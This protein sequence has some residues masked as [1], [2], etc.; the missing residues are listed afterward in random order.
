MKKLI[1]FIFLFLLIIFSTQIAFSQGFEES[2]PEI[3]TSIVLLTLFDT[4]K[5]E[6]Y[7]KNDFFELFYFSEE[8]YVLIP[9]NLI[10][11]YLGVEL[12]FN[13]EL[14]L[15]TLTKDE[16]EIK[17]DLKER[18]YIDHNEWNDEKAIVYGG[19]FYL[20]KKVFSYLTDYQFTWN[21]SFQ[22]LLVEGEFIEKF[23]QEDIEDITDEEEKKDIYKVENKEI[24]GEELK[25]FQLSS[26]H[27]KVEV[28]LEDMRYSDLSKNIVSDLNF[29]GR[30][31]NWAYFLNNDLKYNIDNSEV[32]YDLDRIKFKYQEN[33]ILIIA[34]DHEINMKNTMGKN[35]IQGLYFSLPDKLSFKLIPYTTLKIDLKKGDDLNLLVN[36]KIAKRE[37]TKE[38]KELIIENIELKAGYLNKI[39]III[40]DKDGNKTK[41]TKYLAGAIEILQPKV[42][43]LELM[44]GRFKDFNFPDDEW[45][46]YFGAIR[47]YYALNENMSLYLESAIYNESENPNSTLENEILS[48]ITGFSMRLRDNT[49]INL[50]WLIAGEF[51]NLESGA[52]AEILYSILKG[53]IKAIY[54]YIPPETAEYMQKD[55]GENK[56]ISL[57]FDLNNN[58]TINPVIGQK[59]TLEDN[60]D[61]SDYY[62]FR[63]IY[64]PSWRNYN[65]LSLYY[66]DNTSEYIFTDQDNQSYIFLGDKIRKGI[67]VENNIYGRTFRVSSNLGYYD[68]EIT[69]N[70][71]YKENYQDYEAQLGLYKRFGNYLLFTGNYDGEQQRD[72][73][74][75]RYYDREYNAEL[76]LSLGERISLSLKTKRNEEE[77]ENRIDEESNFIL[78]YYFNRDFS[79]R[80]GFKDY[81]SEFLNDYQSIGLSGSYYYPNNPG[82]ITLS[83]EYIIPD[84]GD[85]GTSFSAAYD[86]IRNDESEIKIE[87]GREY[88]DFANNGYE[89]YATISYS[90]A[91]SF[92][93][94]ETRKTRF[95][96]FEPR[97]IV[98][99]YAYLDE[100]YNGVMDEGERKL[101]DIP[102]R[103]GNM[104]SVSDEEGFYI[105][106]PYFNDTYFLNFDYRNLIADYTPVT[107]EIMVRVKDN[108]NIMQNFGVTINGTISGNVFIDKNANGVKDENDEYLMWA[109]M[110]IVDL[111]K[112]D[113]TDQT[114]EFYFQNV[115]LGF[116]ELILL[117][118]S[119]PKGTK[120]LNGYKQEIFITED[121]LDYQD[122]NIPIVYGD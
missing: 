114:G 86:I 42:K 69:V 33:N 36:N 101:E 22:E 106:K 117:E 63:V 45:E 58:W 116:H 25:G 37:Y 81:H 46:G 19:E 84:E 13:R 6:V 110:E 102:M 95:T 115:P 119:L 35:D 23:S 107:E 98:A 44:G 89:N 39:E 47:S 99:G 59:N 113:Y 54:I 70:N 67:G 30:F 26:V 91:F 51:D 93:G 73:Q 120:P 2:T 64:N 48:S 92:I 29:Y 121:Q 71:I 9:A 7:E 8:D 68:N 28:N 77:S 75:L 49:V 60:I 27:Y 111:N 40:T 105:F 15:L 82:Y 53:Y 11:D 61:E 87:A 17:V 32:D 109:G 76:R 18:K 66:E 50:D 80:A 21:N 118:E 14:S 122:I 104:M 55:E 108:Q 38:K 100:N 74:G 1:L 41:E 16:K 96:D 4:N 20:S 83:A 65:A 88:A 3:E 62:N 43:E 10:A 112:K 103:L 85:P 12:N 94:G 34:G 90:H 52:Q 78:N 31:N 56:S 57:R 5:E 79:L 97:P 72:D 24:L